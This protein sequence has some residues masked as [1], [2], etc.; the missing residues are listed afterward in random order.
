MKQLKSDI[1]IAYLDIDAHH[2]DGVQRF[3][4]KDPNVL[5]I[6]FHE[7]GRYLF[8]GTGEVNEIGQEDGKFFA[9]NYPLLPGFYD[10]LYL[11]LFRKSIPEILSIYKPDLL[12]TQLGVDAYIMDPLSQ[13]GLSLSAYRD[14][15]KEI[16]QYTR[17][18][19]NNKWLAVGGGGYLVTVVPRAWSI[20]LAQMLQVELNNEVPK[21]WKKECYRKA[22]DEVT[23]TEM[24]DKNDKLIL[25]L[26]AHPELKK[27][28]KDHYNMLIK[29][30]QENYIPNLKL[31][32]KK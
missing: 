18:Y 10:E 23:P 26:L 9:I 20:F 19:C 28:M 31:A 2:A 24:F 11:N 4:Y 30:T 16:H 1:R 8:P 15:A 7:S 14:I 6:S 3:F 32:L 25:E 29:I 21:N 22:S 5:T 27:E 13:L 17:K 12:V